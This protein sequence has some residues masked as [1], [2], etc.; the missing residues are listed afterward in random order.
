M[1]GDYFLEF[2]ECVQK[3]IVKADKTY[4]IF[5]AGNTNRKKGFILKFQ[6]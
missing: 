6:E 2:A 5:N 1:L 4:I 3:H